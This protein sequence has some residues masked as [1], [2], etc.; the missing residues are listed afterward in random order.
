MQ[1]KQIEDAKMQLDNEKKAFDDQKWGT[2]KSFK[3]IIY[4]LIT[5]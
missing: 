5:L 4:L 1:I 3:W 2:F